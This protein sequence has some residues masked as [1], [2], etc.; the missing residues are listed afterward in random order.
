[1]EQRLRP[2]NDSEWLTGDRAGRGSIAARGGREQS[3]RKDGGYRRQHGNFRPFAS[4]GPGSC[5]HR[6]PPV[7]LWVHTRGRPVH[8]RVPSAAAPTFQLLLLT[9]VTHGGKGSTP[10]QHLESVPSPTPIFYLREQGI[11]DS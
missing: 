10:S 9:A 1:M 7:V 8:E 2:G 5:G 11:P 4:R 3:L 6:R